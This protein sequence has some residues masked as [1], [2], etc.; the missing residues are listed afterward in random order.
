MIR[1]KT[2]CKW[3]LRSKRPRITKKTAIAIATPTY[4]PALINPLFRRILKDFLT[5]S[6]A[7]LLKWQVNSSPLLLKLE[8]IVNVKLVLEPSADLLT[9]PSLISNP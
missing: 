6:S 3:M 2:L 5:A 1:I 7:E 9:R 4:T 8:G